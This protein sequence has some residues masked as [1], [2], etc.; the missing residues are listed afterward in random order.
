[1][2]FDFDERRPMSRTIPDSDYCTVLNCNSIL[3]VDDDESNRFLIDLYLKDAE[4]QIDVANNGREACELA[5]NKSYALILMD[6]YMPIMDGFKAT[7]QIRNMTD[8]DSCN[9]RI[10]ALTASSSRDVA[11]QCIQV[12][13]DAVLVKPISKTVLLETIAELLG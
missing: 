4:T 2:T 6:M 3:V 8:S 11:A 13:C 7:A 9:A 1:M 12:G 10:I 5:Q